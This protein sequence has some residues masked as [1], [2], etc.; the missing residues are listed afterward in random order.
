MKYK[1]IKGNDGVNRTLT[2]ISFSVKMDYSY[3]PPLAQYLF[4]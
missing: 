3:S 4:M 2:L 1:G